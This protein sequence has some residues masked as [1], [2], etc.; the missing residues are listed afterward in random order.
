MNDVMAMVLAGG[1]VDSMGVLTARR[2]MASVPF[3]G[4]YRVVDFVLTN[5]SESRIEPVGIL[6]QYRPASLMDHVGIGRPW[7]Y[8]GRNRELVFLPPYEGTLERDWYRGTA[9][10]IHQNLHFLNRF[11]RRDV[12]I[13]SGD[14]A[15]RMDYRPILDYHRRMDADLTMVFKRMDCGTPSRFGVGVLADDGRVTDYIEKPANPPTNLASLTIYVFR[16]E[17]LIDSVK[18]NA[19]TGRTFQLYDEVLPN[20]VRNGRVFGWI[21]EGAWEYLRPLSGWYDAHM[22]ML[23][24]GGLGVP[25]DRLMT[26]LE[27]TGVETSPPAFFADGSEI[28]TSLV[29]P[30]ARIHGRVVNSVLFPGVR[31]EAGAV[32]E[33]SVLLNGVVIEAGARVIGAVLD[34]GCTIGR[35]AV[36][37]GG[38]SLVALGKGVRME[39]GAIVPPGTEMPPVDWPGTGD[40]LEVTP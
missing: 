40:P 5:L 12:L 21:H 28:H 14:H 38:E 18:R 10:A 8:N 29:A 3:G 11:K 9:D 32:V 31:V 26:N 39:P 24:P 7:D 17:I 13:A 20:L 22:R 25:L 33:N 4:L 6:S 37:D 19:S 16:K 34:K 23:R 27:A 30:G 15:Y 2:S 35:D 36:L 1:R